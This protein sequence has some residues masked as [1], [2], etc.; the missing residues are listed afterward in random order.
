MWRRHRRIAVLD[1]L[2]ILFA[3]GS[4]AGLLF[5][6]F[7]ESVPVGVRVAIFLTIALLAIASFYLSSKVSYSSINLIASGQIRSTFSY[8][9]LLEMARDGWAVKPG[10]MTI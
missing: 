7:N 10:E 5:A 3:L 9:P 2:G 1:G 6:I 8:P 4:I